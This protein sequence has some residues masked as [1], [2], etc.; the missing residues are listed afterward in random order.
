MK[1][2]A[3]VS[4]GKDSFYALFKKEKD[5][6]C[7]LSMKSENPDSYMFH[8]PNIHLVDLQAQ[9]MDL[10]VI[11]GHTKG[12]KEKELKEL[13]ELIKKAISDYKIEGIVTGALHSQYQKERIEK[14][15]DELN[16]EMVS[17]LW[18]MDQEQEMRELIKEGFEIIFTKVAAFGLDKS[19]LGKIITSK[20]V[21]KLVEL[22]KKYKINIAGEGGEFESL[23]LNCPLFK[24]RIKITDYEIIEEDENT[25]RLVVKKAGVLSN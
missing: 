16:L 13:K 19:W 24:K 8:T 18:G 7:L 2:A 17:P 25:A 14:I 10:P 12:E 3:L 15:C 22:H 21:D 5:I 20:D 23:V 11:W 1:L 6:V 4:G 9:E